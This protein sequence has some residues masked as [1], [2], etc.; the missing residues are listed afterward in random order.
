MYVDYKLFVLLFISLQEMM[1]TAV[2]R[3]SQYVQLLTWFEFH[4]PRTHADRQDL[5]NAIATLTELDRGMRECKM[6]MER[7]KQLVKLTRQI[8]N[9][10]VGSFFVFFFSTVL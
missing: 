4:T 2:R 1:L 5:N 7:E 10:P 9:C 8:I 6:R 3:I